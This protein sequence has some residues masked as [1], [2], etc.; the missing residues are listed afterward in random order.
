M[1]EKFCKSL[2]EHALKI[3]NIEKKNRIPYTNEE[4]ES[5]LNQINCHICKKRF[6]HKYTNDENYCKVKNHCYYTGKYRGAEHSICNLKCSMPKDIPVLFHSGSNFDC[7]FII[8]KLKQALHKKC[9]YSEF[10]PYSV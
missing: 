3:T 1:H 2:R 10:F 9:P 6:E 8:K 7:H 5:Y 4:Y